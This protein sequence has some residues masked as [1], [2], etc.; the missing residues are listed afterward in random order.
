MFPITSRLPSDL[1][2]PGLSILPNEPVDT[3][4]PLKSPVGAIFP[5]LSTFRL[6][7]SDN[8]LRKRY[9]NSL[10]VFYALF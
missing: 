8:N 6:S 3:T 2:L 4:E 10:T 9:Y 5:V 1:I 7:A